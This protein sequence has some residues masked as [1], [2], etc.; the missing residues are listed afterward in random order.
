MH[1][2]NS[3]TVIT[4][5]RLLQPERLGSC[6]TQSPFRHY[7]FYQCLHGFLLF[8]ITHWPFSTTN[9]SLNCICIRSLQH[10]SCW[11]S[12]SRTPQTA[13]IRCCYCTWQ[14]HSWV[15]HCYLLEKCARLIS[16]REAIACGVLTHHSSA[17][18]VSNWVARINWTNDATHTLRLISTPVVVEA[19][20]KPTEYQN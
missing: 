1:Q 20:P 18:V 12:S 5:L 14:P 13:S 6:L 17:E 19:I 16:T 2:Q 10:S 3:S 8:P 15:L 7:E 9:P 4:I 11:T